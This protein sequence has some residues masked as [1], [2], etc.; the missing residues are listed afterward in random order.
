MEPIFG[1]ESSGTEDVSPENNEPEEI[2]KAQE[3]P[4]EDYEKKK[5]ELLNKIKSFGLATAPLDNLSGSKKEQ[6]LKSSEEEVRVESSETPASPEVPE[7]DKDAATAGLLVFLTILS[8][9]MMDAS[10][11]SRAKTF[12]L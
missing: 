4:R 7:A 9:G 6:S 3:I 8:W 2:V 11:A 1:L 12:R 10:L 5:A